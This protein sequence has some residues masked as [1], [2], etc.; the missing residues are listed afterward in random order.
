M[1]D[2]HI[3]LGRACELLGW[4]PRRLNKAIVAHQVELYGDLKDGRATLIATA[5]LDRLKLPAV[6]PA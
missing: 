4:S 2:E 1:E 3:T 6:R 5:D